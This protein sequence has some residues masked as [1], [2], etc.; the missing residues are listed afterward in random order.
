MFNKTQKTEIPKQEKS[1]T[2]TLNDQLLKSEERVKDYTDHLKRLQA[3]FENYAKRVDKE[4]EDFKK[5]AVEKLILK[6]LLIIDDFERA[7]IEFE[8]K[9]LPKELMEG[10]RMIFKNLHKTLNEEG[11]K[12]IDA[13]NKP[14]D[15]YKHEVLLHE[16]RKDCPDNI[17]LDELQKGYMLGNKVIRYAKVKINKITEDEQNE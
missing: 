10:I 1:E 9:D 17:V 13:K 12:E 16:C 11:V 8:K 14:F 15:P 5:Y 4:R 7:M 3:E 6:L 2:E